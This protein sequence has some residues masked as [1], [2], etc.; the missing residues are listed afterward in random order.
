M[1]TIA[2]LLGTAFRVSPF[3]IVGTVAAGYLLMGF[4]FWSAQ[5]FIPDVIFKYQNYVNLYIPGLIYFMCIEPIVGAGIGTIVAVIA[6]GK[7]IV[8][9]MI[10][11]LFVAA[12]GTVFL[13]RSGLK[14][15]AFTGSGVTP[16]VFAT[17]TVPIV[18]LAGGIFIRRHRGA[19]ARR[20]SGA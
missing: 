4:Q 18:I 14:A 13:A 11:S 20:V 9:T 3:L 12:T 6:K 10:L 16:L 7:E 1:K 5:K 15:E 8:S 19:Y 17:I 2:H